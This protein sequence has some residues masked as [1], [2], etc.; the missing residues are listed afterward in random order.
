MGGGRGLGGWLKINFSIN[1]SLIPPI[2]SNLPC[3]HSSLYCAYLMASQQVSHTLPAFFKKGR[4]HIFFIRDQL[5]QD[6][7]PLICGLDSLICLTYGLLDKSDKSAPLRY[8]RVFASTVRTL[9]SESPSQLSD[10]VPVSFLSNILTP[11]SPRHPLF[12]C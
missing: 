4:C 2:T 1:F 3:N 9:S 10:T 6:R 7:S 11:S 5:Q 8:H 12:W